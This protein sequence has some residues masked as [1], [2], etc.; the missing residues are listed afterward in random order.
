MF[1]KTGLFRLSTPEAHALPSLL[2]DSEQTSIINHSTLPEVRPAAE[3]CSSRDPGSH[4]KLS[5]V[6]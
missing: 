5:R 1:G 6:G 2:L 3:S 4:Y